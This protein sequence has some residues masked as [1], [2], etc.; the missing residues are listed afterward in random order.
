MP[1][2]RET[3]RWP[4]DSI[5]W[6]EPWGCRSFRA[7][8]PGLAHLIG[9]TGGYLFGFALSAWLCGFARRSGKPVSW[10]AGLAW[11]GGALLTVYAL[12]AAW[13]KFALDMTWTKAWMVG[14]VP[15]I[16]W[17]GLKVVAALVCV[18]YLFRF[19]LLPGQR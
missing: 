12:G 18:R 13:L 15:F 1:S 2:A 14:I 9:P 19:G 6:P 3:G 7:A 10:S 11:G 8:T 4:W 5:F 17:D 16:P